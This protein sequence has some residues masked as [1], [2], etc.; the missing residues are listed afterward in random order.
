MASLFGPINRLNFE[1]FLEDSNGQPISSL[2]VSCV[3]AERGS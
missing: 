2:G 1:G 3:K